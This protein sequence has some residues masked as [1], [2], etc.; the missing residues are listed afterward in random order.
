M[1]GIPE[2]S[3]D[4]RRSFNGEERIALFLAADGRCAECGQELEPGWHGD[5]IEPWSEGGPTDVINGRATCPSCNLK[6]GNRSMAISSGLRSWQQEARERYHSR[7]GGENSN[8]LVVATPGAGKTTFALT[9][10]EDLISRGTISNIVVVAPTKHLRR[11]WA[12]AGARVGIKLDHLFENKNGAVGSDFDG[13]VA[14]YQAIASAPLLWKRLCASKRTLVIFDEIHHAGDGDGLVWGDALKDSFESATRRLLLSGTPFRTDGKPLPFVAYDE[15]RRA[16]PSYSYDYGM[17]LADGGV[18]RPAVFPAW[19]GKSKWRRSGQLAVTEVDL[20]D[21][22]KDEIPPALKAAL[23]PT[24]AWIPSVLQEAHEALLRMRIDTP[25]AG[26]LVIASD[27]FAA[28]A[29]AAI[30]ERIA[31]VQ[32]PVAISDEPN[33]SDIIKN[34]ARGNAPWIVAVQMIAEGVDIPRLGVGVYASRVRTKMFF[35]QVVGRFV[36]MRG[37]E[38]PTTARLFIPSIAVLLAFAQDIEK[39]V[40]AVLAEEEKQIREMQDTHGQGDTLIPAYETVSSSVAT[41]H[42]TI[43]GGSQFTPEQL[44]FAQRTM[45]MAGPTSPSVTAEWVAGLLTSAQLLN[46]NALPGQRADT[47]VEP[48]GDQKKSLRRLIHRKAGRLSALTNRPYEHINGELNQS[49]GNVVKTATM[50]QLQKR[51]AMLDAA[52][53]EAQKK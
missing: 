15:T 33:A 4:R 18:V 37:D 36:R 51:L 35:T 28:T 46:G 16:V 38:D 42:V 43:A 22:D 1:A 34:F 49:L 8:F 7:N 5:H 26:G 32:V 9:I 11:Q 50:E 21:A 25:D 45:A 29:Y 20:S 13:V 39:M 40:D 3:R 41:H 17:A 2:G 10:A 31:G 47:D 53:K 12:E 24:G 23:D 6:K 19:D 27:Q 48:L 44:D 52:I 14:T 30:L